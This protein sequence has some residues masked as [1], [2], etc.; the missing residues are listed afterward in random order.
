MTL[1][2]QYSYSYSVHPKKRYALYQ[3]L[4]LSKLK[5]SLKKQLEGKTHVA[6]VSL[7]EYEDSV[8]NWR[9]R[10][11]GGGYSLGFDT[12]TLTQLASE[13]HYFLFPC[14]YANKADQLTFIQGALL[15][16]LQGWLAKIHEL[17]QDK[18][19]P[20]QAFIKAREIIRAEATRVHE[21]MLQVACLLKDD[22]DKQELEWRL[23][24]KEIPAEHLHYDEVDGYFLP[25]APFDYGD[26]LTSITLNLPENNLALL[27]LKG[28][29]KSVKQDS[30]KL[31][32]S[33]QLSRQPTYT[34]MPLALQIRS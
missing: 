30:I 18:P 24:S 20:K 9:K 33:K 15:G 6:V 31:S 19:D 14:Y 10:T 7:S 27:G 32:L 23:L 34:P 5:S 2:R 16:G 21:I 1:V 28:Y 13:Q 17:Y 12:N 11:P 29:L 25:Y 22:H 3:F 26:S 8:L 4:I